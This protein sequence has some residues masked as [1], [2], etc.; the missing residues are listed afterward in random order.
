MW[1]GVCRSDGYEIR[2]I[3]WDGKEWRIPWMDVMCGFGTE[4]DLISQTSVAIHETDKR[5]GL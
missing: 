3:R 4:C 2:G 5:N 1:M